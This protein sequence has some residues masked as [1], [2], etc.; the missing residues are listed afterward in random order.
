MLLYFG[1]RV[2]SLKDGKTRGLGGFPA[3]ERLLQY[4]E[5]SAVDVG[6]IFQEED[7]NSA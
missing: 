5:G 7:I 4:R 6:A 3:M 1:R 2:N